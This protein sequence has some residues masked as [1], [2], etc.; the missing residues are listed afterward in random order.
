MKRVRVNFIIDLAALVTFCISLV[1]GLVL[2]LVL[3]TGGR[4]SPASFAGLTRSAWLNMHNLWSLAFAAL[5][6][7]HLLLHLNFFKKAAPT[8]FREKDSSKKEP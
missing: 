4:W 7:I 3:P 2:Y 8:C 6:I 5:V 1:S